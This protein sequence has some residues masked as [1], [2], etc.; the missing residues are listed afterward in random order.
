[1]YVN[2]PSENHSE[3][4]GTYVSIRKLYFVPRGTAGTFSALDYDGN[5]S[6][7][8]FARHSSWST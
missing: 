6:A 3:R 7:S 2:A 8:F 5:N 4:H 1:M